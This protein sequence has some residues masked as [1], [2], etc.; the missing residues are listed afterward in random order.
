MKKIA[1]M[2]GFKLKDFLD[3]EEKELKKYISEIFFLEVNNLAREHRNKK[4]R[5]RSAELLSF[6]VSGR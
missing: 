5:E 4:A 1:Q 6:M 2:V 3:S